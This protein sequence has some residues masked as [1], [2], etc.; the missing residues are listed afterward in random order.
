MASMRNISLAFL[1]LLANAAWADLIFDPF[2][3]VLP[4]SVALI[5]L[6]GILLCIFGA[7]YLIKKYI[8]KGGKK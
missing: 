3:Y 7:W 6:A 2:Y 4:L 5:I 8:M 1:L